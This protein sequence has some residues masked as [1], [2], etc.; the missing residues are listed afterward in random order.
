MDLSSHA[1]ARF[2][3]LP[4]GSLMLYGILQERIMTTPYGD[5]WFEYSVFLVL[6]NRFAACAVAALVL[7][8]R[9]DSLAPTAPLYKFFMISVSNVTATTCQY[10][11]LRYV[12]FPTQTLG[13]CAKMIPVMLWGKCIDNKSY[14]WADYL[15]TGAVTFGSTLFLL[16]G[17]LSEGSAKHNQS[18]S[19]YGLLLM[20][21]Y[22]G[23]DG[24]TSTFQS[25]LF[26]SYTM[27]TYNQM[28]YVNMCSGIISFVGL[29]FSGQLF[30]ALGFVSRHP[31]L[32]SDAII[33]SV[34]AVA[35]QFCITY[36]IKEYG[37]LI[38][39]TIM[40]TRQFL[41]ILFSCL[42]FA[43]PLTFWQWIGT[44]IIF[45]ALYYQGFAKKDSHGHGKS[46]KMNTLSDRK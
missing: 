5:E 4:P 40:T 22:L 34:S 30:G 9:R 3:L 33:L 38:Y 35:G 6:N 1:C 13:K 7:L 27:S 42:L 28:M 41:S 16:T 17:D 39:A 32:L 29:L 36:T 2:A 26:S 14:A 45:G 43:H 12:N 46:V 11:A 24:F 44:I 15:V 19:V 31:E 18:T 37:A 10:E 21:G 25:K 23:F 8:I 20:V